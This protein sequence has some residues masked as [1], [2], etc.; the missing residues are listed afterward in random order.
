MTEEKKEGILNRYA[1]GEME[2][3]NK[4]E[5]KCVL[6]YVRFCLKSSIEMLEL[7]LN[8]TESDFYQSELSHYNE[9]VETVKNLLG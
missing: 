9:E 7:P 4:T 5:L 3:F 8:E 6:S 2:T 1:N